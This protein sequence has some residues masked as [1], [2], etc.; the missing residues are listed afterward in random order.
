MI[1][2][3]HLTKMYGALRAVDA[4]S[5]DV[6]A[7]EMYGFLGP[8]GAGKTTTIRLLLGVI[9][10]TSGEIWLRGARVRG[11]SHPGK[12][13]IGVVAEREVGMDDL[14]AWEYLEF[15]AALY[16]L[17]RAGPRIGAL[18]EALG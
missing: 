7:G 3:D 9:R 10:P 8:N 4:L 15:F 5:L 14:T 16:R 1:R 2:T 6:R 17:R 11:P 12:G 13:R 18:L